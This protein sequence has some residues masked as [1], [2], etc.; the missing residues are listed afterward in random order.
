MCLASAC[1]SDSPPAG[2]APPAPNDAGVDSGGPAKPIECDVVP[3]SSCPEPAPT[4]NATVGAIVATRCALG[5]CHDGRGEQWPL[6][7]YAHVADW[8]GEIRSMVADCTMP[9]PDAGVPITTEE[10]QAVLAWVRCGH[11]E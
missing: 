3:P 8:S 11:P 1:G 5:G 6:V 7:D 9:P 4:W 10:R 2:P